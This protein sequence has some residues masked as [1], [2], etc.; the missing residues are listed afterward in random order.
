MTAGV[1]AR[2]PQS[3]TVVLAGRKVTRMNHRHDGKEPLTQS[4]WIKALVGALLRFA[5]M[6]V[7]EHINKH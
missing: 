5:A 6:I 7:W 1:R 3:C 4:N 2:Y